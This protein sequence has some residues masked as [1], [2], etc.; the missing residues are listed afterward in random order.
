MG[1]GMGGSLDVVEIVT[2][3]MVA[4]VVGRVCHPSKQFALR[5]RLELLGPR[6][7]APCRDAAYGSDTAHPRKIIKEGRYKD[8]H[9]QEFQPPERDH[10]QTA[11]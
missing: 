4:R 9:L 2:G 7:D 5:N 11:R 1:G 3:L 10:S 8:Q 6:E